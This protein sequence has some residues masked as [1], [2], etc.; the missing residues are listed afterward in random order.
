MAG[1]TGANAPVQTDR[2]VDGWP[3]VDW[4]VSA[5]I[6]LFC[7]TSLSRGSQT[8]RLLL[9]HNLL[10]DVVSIPVVQSLMKSRPP[11]KLRRFSIAHNTFLF[12]LSLYMCVETIRQVISFR[13]LAMM[14]CM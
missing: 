7:T 8:A 5:A 10:A 14:P 13:E 2:R 3:L 1:W 4:R 9:S 6:S 11:F 12:A